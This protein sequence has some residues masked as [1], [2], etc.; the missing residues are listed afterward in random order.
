M[1]TSLRTSAGAKAVVDDFE[2]V[3]GFTDPLRARR[4]S[5]LSSV[6]Q[7]CAPLC[8]SHR[9]PGQGPSLHPLLEVDAEAVGDA[10]DVVEE[11][12]DLGGVA[13]GPIC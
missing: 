12:D 1:I 7:A 8:A 10:V 11:G 9:T 6:L 2:Q 4:D 5:G 13:D 3:A